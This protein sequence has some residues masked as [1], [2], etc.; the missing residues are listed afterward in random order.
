MR[1]ATALVY[2]S[3]GLDAPARSQLHR[4]APAPT[5]AR[6]RLGLVSACLALG[7][8]CRQTDSPPRPAEP[9]PEQEAR[10]LVEQARR[11]V[12]A[13]SAGLGP[14]GAAG[15]RVYAPAAGPARLPLLVFLHGLGGT[16]QELAE[17]LRLTE[18]ADAFGF[19][20]IAPEGVLDHSGRRFWNAGPSC[21][22]FDDIAID[23][24]A[25][26]GT[27]IG[28]ATAHPRVDARR[29][30]LVGFSNG[31]FM[32]Y[33][34]ACEMSSR[35]AGIVSI[36]GAGPSDPSTCKPERPISVVQ[37]HGD[38]DPIVKFE[39]GYLFANTRRP[40]IPSAEKSVAA[41][42]KLDACTGDA[43]PS[44]PLDLDP[45]VPGAETQVTSYAGCSGHR[46]ELWRIP[47]GDHTAGL[48]R[49]SIK[50]ILDFIAADRPAGDA[51]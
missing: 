47:G 21:C 11:D 16:G 35:L 14:P 30:Y 17:A 23:H 6:A 42:A 50:A 31:G 45:R 24:I 46:V 51:P 32:A 12:E 20:F 48:N 13:S 1:V 43:A 4:G 9:T 5:R 15:T 28:Q 34:A 26:L 36:A 33:R 3:H 49:Y 19:A 7:V 22:N 27:W 2:P 8:A 25:L 39:G 40:R 41:W 10:A 18:M 29:V 38:R 37:I 44:E